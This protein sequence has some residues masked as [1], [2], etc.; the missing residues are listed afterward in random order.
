MAYPSNKHKNYD[1]I[2]H[3]PHHTSSSHPRMPLMERAAQFSPFSALSGYS[4]AIH[5]TARL[6]DTEKELDEQAK[7]LLDQKLRATYMQIQNHPFLEITYFQP[8]NRKDGGSYTCFA[9][10]VE[11]IDFYKRTVSMQNGPKIP[12]DRIVDITEVG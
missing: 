12:I 10:T 9:G 5:E 8:D 6:T 7:Y 4:E 11:Q 3:L 2:I 1:D